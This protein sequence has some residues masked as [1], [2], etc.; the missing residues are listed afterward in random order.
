MSAIV[1]IS[2]V[3]VEPD[4]VIELAAITVMKAGMLGGGPELL[5]GS[6]AHVPP[7]M[8]GSGIRELAKPL[9]L[10]G[11]GEALLSEFNRAHCAP[12]N[13]TWLPTTALRSPITKLPGKLGVGV[14]VGVGAGVGVGVGLCAGVGVGV[15][16]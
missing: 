7:Q 6:L 4:I 2:P 10:R 15:G 5:P 8:A 16:V 11:A 14:G 9:K 13:V 1:G 3:I 12:Q